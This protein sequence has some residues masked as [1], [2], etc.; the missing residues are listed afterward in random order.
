MTVA[1]YTSDLVDINLCEATAGFTAYGGGGAGIGADPDYAIEGTNAI[2][3]I[4]TASEKGVLFGAA[5]NFTIGADDHFFVWLN[6]ATYGIADTRDNRGL[7]VSIG[8]DTSNFVKFHVNGSDTLPAGGMNPYAIR[9][10]NTTLANRRTLVGTPS[11]TPDSVGGGANITATARFENM[12]VDAMRI[13][14]GYDILNGTGADPEADFAGL[15]LD[16]ESTSEG[17]FQTA[18]GG[19]SWQGKLRIGSTAT[20]CEFLDSNQLLALVNTLDGESLS[21]FTEILIE[22]A[23]SIVNLTNVTFFAL[24]THNPGR[25]E[26]ITSAAVVNLTGCVFNGTGVTVLGTGSTFTNCLF[27]NNA[28]IVTAN[29]A[30]MTT[31]KIEGYEGTV[32]TS[33]LIWNVA[34]DPNGKLDDMTFTKGT[35]ATHAIEFGTTSPLTM[36]LTDVTFVGYNAS[37]GQDDSTIHVKRTTG[38]VT[39]NISGG[40]TP[41]VRTDGA[42]VNVVSSVP[43]TV[44]VKDEA[45][46][47]IENANV[48]IY[49]TS[50]NEIM[51]PTLTNASGVASGSHS[52]STPLAVSV[53]V[54]KGTGG[55]TKYVPVNSPQTISGTGLSVTITMT[56]DTVNSS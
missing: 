36:T 47:A 2:N 53:R 16:D 17:V 25:F 52:G 50:N 31:T 54:R 21:D 9:F 37:D 43:I 14:T 46:V 15:A 39:I 41:S 45:G 3:K 22:N 24:G 40:T 48:A 29:G 6:V 42:T 11:T 28:G 27:L 30:T 33:S 23:S 44:T 1:T 12:A 18:P 7:H 32:N 8:D 13:G 5:G 19:F 4:V 38:T 10:V 26:V 49:D 56:E 34:T 51:A 55:A 20:A 35:A